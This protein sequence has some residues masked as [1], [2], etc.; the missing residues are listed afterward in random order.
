[1]VGHSVEQCISEEEKCVH[2]GESHSTGSSFCQK[3]F[4]EEALIKIQEEEKVTLMRARQTVENNNEYVEIPEQ[5]FTTHYDCK[6][7]EKDK[8]KFSP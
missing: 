7:N 5:Q 1:M 6:M 3:Y 2:C 4:R 8:R